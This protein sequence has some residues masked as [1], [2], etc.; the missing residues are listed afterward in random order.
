MCVPMHGKLQYRKSAGKNYYPS[1]SLSVRWEWWCCLVHGPFKGRCPPPPCSRVSHV[2]SIQSQNAVYLLAFVRDQQVLPPLDYFET[3]ASVFCGLWGYRDGC[4]F[5]VVLV[6]TSLCICVRVEIWCGVMVA[7]SNIQI[8]NSQFS[9][10]N[11]WTEMDDIDS[12][13]WTRSHQVV[14]SFQVLLDSVYVD[15]FWFC[16]SFPHPPDITLRWQKYCTLLRSLECEYEPYAV[17]AVFPDVWSCIVF[18]TW[19]V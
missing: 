16:Q 5:H 9:V 15:L 1:C 13:T 2:Q 17:T 11:I 6:L 8:P 19:P 18:F 12:C 4:L 3:V 14:W 10:W 7:E